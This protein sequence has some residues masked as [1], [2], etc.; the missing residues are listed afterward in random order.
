MNV[1]FETIGNATL[2]AHDG[3][4]VLVTDPWIEGSAYF[5]SWKLSHEVP[6]AQ[7]AAARAARHV[8]FSHGHPDHLSSESLPLFSDKQ[9]LLP[10]HVGGRIAHDLDRQGFRV[11][12]LRDRE[13]VQLS[14]RVRVLCIADYNQDAILLI[15]VNGR[16]IV[17]LNDAS[18]RGWGRFVRKTIR[19][20]RTSFLLA[21]HGY[22]DADM[23]NY[24]DESGARLPLPAR[25]PLGQ[26]IATQC[27]LYGV[28]YFV[29][30]SSMHRYQ[31]TDS[32]WAAPVAATLDDYA[33]GFHA[34]GCELL[35]PFIRFDCER[36]TFERIDP[37]ETPDVLYEPEAFGDRWSDPL[38]R[39]DVRKAQRYFERIDRVRRH[40]DFIN[41]RVGGRDHR[42]EL[43]RANNRGLTFEA[44]RGSLMA[45][46]EGEFFDDLLIGNFTRVVLHGAWGPRRLYPDFTPYVAKYADNG[47]ARS[48]SELAAYF[49]AYRRRAPLAH[50]QHLV[51]IGC[52]LPLKNAVGDALRGRLGR[53]S[54]VYR[55]VKKSYWLLR[56]GI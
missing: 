37:R 49:A 3:A 28:R 36:D 5:G 20:Y 42:L 13:W 18:D 2:I 7:H 40:V 48:R 56:R 8:W 14:P 44:P 21:L 35:P 30:F 19:R 9:I 41:L 11:R 26:T 12:V 32:A 6:P 33:R 34:P 52:V 23:L 38:E 54:P 27:A 46:I 39:D 4:P 47:G 53:D 1:G 50:Y 31:R 43:G 29:P 22:G 55:A 25:V 15:D 16:L 10:D 51:D 24:C 45:A 17:N